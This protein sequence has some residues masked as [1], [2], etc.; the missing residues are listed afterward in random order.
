M[1]LPSRRGRPVCIDRLDTSLVLFAGP[2]YVAYENYPK[3]IP[4]SA[5]IVP[6][7]QMHRAREFCAILG[8]LGILRTA[9]YPE[10]ID[11]ARNWCAAIEKRSSL[12]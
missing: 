5:V 10:H 11:H 1:V 3:W 7:A 8:K 4:P 12:A 2:V 6:H 9:W